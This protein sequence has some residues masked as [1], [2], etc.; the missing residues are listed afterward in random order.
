MTRVFKFAFVLLLSLELLSVAIT[1]AYAA[2]VNLP[3]F[4]VSAPAPGRV[5]VDNRLS[6]W[7]VSKPV[8]FVDTYLKSYVRYGR[9][10]STNRCVVLS[11]GT[12]PN[13]KI[14]WAVTSG[15]RCNITINKRAIPSVRTRLVSHEFAHCFGV[16]HNPKRTSV[17]Y[18]YITPSLPYVFTSS[19]KAILRSK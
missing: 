8:A 1:P 14:G 12:P 19:E 5:M 3:H 13:G 9:C 11:F 18:S 10:N 16:H 17:M 4:T 15:K 7:S 6:G 2:T